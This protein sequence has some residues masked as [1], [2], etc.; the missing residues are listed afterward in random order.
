MTSHQKPG[1]TV[2][3]DR[4]AR[5]S[6][7]IKRKKTRAIDPMTLLKSGASAG[8]DAKGPEVIARVGGRVIGLSARVTL[9]CL[10]LLNILNC[11][12]LPS[13]VSAQPADTAG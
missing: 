7:W 8:A 13:Y 12:D 11:N 2:G 4:K 10:L 3:S 9:G 6:E 1:Q 5:V